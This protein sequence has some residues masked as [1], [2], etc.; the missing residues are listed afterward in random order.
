M[1]PRASGCGTD[2]VDPAAIAQAAERTRS[3]DSA[4]MRLKVVTKGFGLPLPMT[5]AGEGV[6]SLTKP[7]LELTMDLGPL[8][9]LAGA[10]DD[11]KVR[12]RVRGKD[13][14]VDPPKLDGFALPDGAEWLTL[15]LQKAIE[16]MGIDAAGLGEIMTIDPGAQL[17]VL[18]TAD[19]VQELGTETIDGAE[20]THYRGTPREVL[21]L[22]T[23]S[24]VVE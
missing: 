12:V 11:G 16:A 14:A 21:A 5:V 9:A 10:G 1:W 2:D 8:V 17:D 24:S 23:E 6:T 13:V 20:T 19:D 3:A 22:D 15:D 7:E 4:E 18:R